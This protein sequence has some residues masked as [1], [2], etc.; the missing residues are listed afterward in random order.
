MQSKLQIHLFSNN[1]PP[2]SLS[3]F[4]LVLQVSMLVC[5]F[6]RPVSRFVDVSLLRCFG[7]NSHRKRWARNGGKECYDCRGW[8][9]HTLPKEDPE[10]CEKLKKEHKKKMEDKA[11]LLPNPPGQ[12]QLVPVPRQ[13]KHAARLRGTG[14]DI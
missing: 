8:Y 10:M 11:A 3:S 1:P 9:R 2:A 12:Y 4:S 13:K 5:S 7:G 6:V 14:T